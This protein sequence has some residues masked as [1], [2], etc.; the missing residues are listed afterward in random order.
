M[1]V[2]MGKLEVDIKRSSLPLGSK[3]LDLAIG[4]CRETYLQSQYHIGMKYTTMVDFIIEESQQSIRDRSLRNEN[5][6][7]AVRR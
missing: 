1:I 3:G 4:I 5:I 6:P 2:G 7:L